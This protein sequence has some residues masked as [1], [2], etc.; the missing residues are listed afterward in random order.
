MVTVKAPKPPCTHTHTK[1]SVGHPHRV[2]SLRQAKMDS[3][4]IKTPTTIAK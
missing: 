3:V 1:L 2:R 4:R